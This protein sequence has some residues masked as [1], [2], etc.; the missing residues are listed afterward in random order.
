MNLRNTFQFLAA[1]ALLVGMPAGAEDIEL[2]VNAN[3]QSNPPNV[4]FVI[5]NAGSFTA[6]A[7]GAECRLPNANSPRTD[8]SGKVGGIEQCALYRVIEA[9]PVD[10]VNIGVMVYNDPNVVDFLGFYHGP[11][12]T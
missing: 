5:D 8:L 2:F 4:L 10:S 3:P 12:P 11:K 1:S 7:S 6:N 9:L